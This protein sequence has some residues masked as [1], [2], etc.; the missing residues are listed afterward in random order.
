MESPSFGVTCPKDIKRYADR[1][2]NYTIINWAPIVAT[3]NSGV[4]PNV[5]EYGVPTGN[6][7]YQG[8]HEVIYNASDAAG[9]YRIFKF[10]VTLEGKLKLVP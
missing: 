4:V 6:R 1:G 9:N 8:R 5:T 2:R 3:D 10:H 7:F